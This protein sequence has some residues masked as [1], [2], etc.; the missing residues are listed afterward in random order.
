M[1]H[2]QSWPE[3]SI[4]CLPWTRWWWPGSAVDADNISKLLA[5]YRAAGLGGVEITPIYGVR[6]CEDRELPYMGDEW[7]SMLQ[8]TI[9]D[10]SGLGMGVDLATTTGWPIG[11]PIVNDD[12]SEDALVLEKQAIKAGEMFHWSRDPGLLQA[13]TAVTTDGTA[14]NLLDSLLDSSDSSVTCDTDSTVYTVTQ[15]FAGRMVKRAA[16]GGEGRCINPFLRTAVGSYFRWFTSKLAHL[17]PGDIRAQFHDSF[18]YLANWAPD[19]LDEFEARRGYDL[20]LHLHNLAGEGDPDLV[21][22]VKTDY[23]ETVSDMLLH[24]FTRYWTA[25]SHTAGS[26]TRNQA[27]GSP[28]NLLDLY[29]AV[30]IP[31]TEMFGPSGNPHIAKFA[32]S[33]AHVRGNALSSSETCTWLAE[34]FHVSLGMAKSAIDQLFLSG[35]NHIFY[36]GTCYSPQDAAWPGWLFYASTTFA[37]QDPLWRDFA[38]LNQYVTRCQSILQA[39]S[40]GARVLLYW[41]LH[42]LWMARPDLFM[43]EINGDWLTGSQVGITAESLW[44]AGHDYDWVSDRQLAEAH[45]S[46]GQ[47]SLQGGGY[48]AIV[49]PPCH[50][51]SDV[52]FERLMELAN[53]GA[54]VLFV[55]GIPADV[56]GYGLLNDR[57]E[58]LQRMHGHIDFDEPT[59]DGMHTCQFGAGKVICGE[60]AAKMLHAAGVALEPLGLAFGAPP[61]RRIHSD[62]IDRFIVNRTGHYI[63]DWFTLP[64]EFRTAFLLDPLTGQLGEAAVRSNRRGREVFVALPAGGS[65]VVRTTSELITDANPWLYYVPVDVERRMDGDWHLEFME[66]G[67]GLPAPLVTPGAP[68]FWSSSHAPHW[69]GTARYHTEFTVDVSLPA[70][71]QLEFHELAGSARVYVDDILIATLISSPFT[72]LLPKLATGSHRLGVEVTSTAANRI[73]Q[74][75]RDSVEWKIFKDINIVDIHYKPLDASSWPVEPA[76]LNGPVVLRAMQAFTPR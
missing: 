14:T 58:N 49:V 60:S 51:I 53:D 5:A 18:E 48:D 10:A 8:R 19:L 31:E 22:R 30:D 39:G 29:A 33:A 25:F 3:I 38:Y 76:G 28:G 61:V 44:N 17:R 23:R 15:K 36:H 59:G 52:T 37:P 64:D 34:H 2:L 24:N 63:A 56:P 69:S 32:S 45:F 50:Y 46:G 68:Q 62:Y 7:L 21:N 43:L 1:E 4:G 42:D 65:I 26:L 47:I 70:Q 6:N 71:W 12:D 27:H 40:P 35:I 57:R 54:N 9:A 73:R 74:M 55:G 75:D 20:R 16:P 67:A 13:V 11:G 66:G 41:P 72:L